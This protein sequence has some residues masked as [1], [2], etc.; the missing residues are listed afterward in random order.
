MLEAVLA[1]GFGLLIGSFLNVC[2]YRL[3]RDLSVVRPRSYCPSCEHTIAWFDNVPLLS[4]GILRGHCR[5][6]NAAISVRYPLVEFLTGG[7]FFLYVLRMGPTLA[8]VKYCILGA[9]LVGLLFA[10]LEE[11]IL[12][13]EFTL[14]GT[15]A[16]LALSFLVRVQDITAHAI[17][18]LLKIDAS[19][20]VLSFAESLFGALLPA[21]FLWF[22]GYLYEKARKREGMGFGDIKMMLMIGAFLGMKDALLTLI[23]GSIAGSL[24][25][26]L[27]IRITHKEVSTYEL[28]FGTFLALGAVVVTLVGPTVFEWYD[29]VGR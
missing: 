19:P 8:A 3:P 10:D 4:Y 16:G 14:G 28:P 2:V 26:Y 1:F 18:W 27:Y 9:L 15:L 22:G 21:F 23:I 17:F 24:V 5:H 6:C 20:R 11:R 13:D 29:T 7:L 25:G 12:P